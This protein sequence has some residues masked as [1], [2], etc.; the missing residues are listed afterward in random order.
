MNPAFNP[1]ATFPFCPDQTDFLQTRGPDG[2]IAIELNLIESF[3]GASRPDGTSHTTIHLTNNN[4]YDS[5]EDVPTLV[6]RYAAVKR[7]RYDRE[8]QERFPANPIVPAAGGGGEP[9]LKAPAEPPSQSSLPGPPVPVIPASGIVW[10]NR[11]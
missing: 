9:V 2:F 3:M 8:R 10:R 4:S 1:S 7:L 5:V 6:A 11:G